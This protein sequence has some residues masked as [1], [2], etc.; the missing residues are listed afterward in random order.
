M[1]TVYVKK[2]GNDANAGTRESPV[3]TVQRAAYLIRAASEA[4]SEII[5]MDDETY[6]EGL[7]GQNAGTPV[8]PTVTVTG[9]TIM[10]ET[11]SDGLPVVSPVIQGSGSGNTQ[12]YAFY[13]SEGWTIKGLTFENY[14]I[15]NSTDSAVITNRSPG[16]GDDGITVELCTFRHITGS[17]ITFSR[18]SFLPNRHFVKSNTFYDI[19]TKSSQKNMVIISDG[20]TERKATVVN[21]VFYDWQPQE[22]GATFILG[23]STNSQLPEIIISHNTFGTSSVEANG[24]STTRANYGVVSPRSKFE[25]NIIKDQTM[26]GTNSSFAQLDSGEANYNIYFNV[27]GES[28]HAPFGR[29]SA[30]TSSNGNQEIDPVLKGPFVGDSA[31]Y[32]LGGTSSPAFDAAIGSSD[33]T[34]DRT[35]RTRAALD[36]SA[37]NTGIFDIGAFELTGLFQ[38][39]T[40]SSSVDIADDFLI[41]RIPNAQGQYKKGAA[42]GNADRFGKDVDQVP[43]TSAIQGAVPGFIRS[44][45]GN[46]TKITK[47]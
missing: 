30:P 28:S 12:S 34:I 47:G 18:G 15:T 14:D 19:T 11:G 4:D 2:T 21:N 40:V 3:L 31:N 16:N 39:E 1:A 10:A 36:V 13:C 35:G 20:T 24:G 29:A 45:R 32:R 37:L 46:G 25:Y 17:C 9:L 23:G 33:V 42:E 44:P 5:I 26:A 41:K 8:S 7:I 38:L 43:M 6:V 22:T 27:S